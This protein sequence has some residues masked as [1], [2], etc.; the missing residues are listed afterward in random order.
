VID[1]LP[2]RHYPGRYRHPLLVGLRLVVLL[3]LPVVLLLIPLL[4]IKL[5]TEVAL[6]PDIQFWPAPIRDPNVLVSFDVSPGV[7]GAGMSQVVTAAGRCRPG[8]RVLLLAAGAFM[9]GY[10]LLVVGLGM[11][12][13]VLTPLRTVQK[14]GQGATVRL[15]QERIAFGAESTKG[16]EGSLALTRPSRWTGKRPLVCPGRYLPVA[17]APGRCLGAGCGRAGC[18]HGCPGQHRVVHLTARAVRR[19]LPATARTT[20]LSYNILRS[21]LG[22]L[23]LLNIVSLGVL[24]LL[25]A[26]PSDRPALLSPAWQSLQPGGSLSLLLL[27]PGHGAAVV[28]HSAASAP[29]PGSPTAQPAASRRAG[30]RA[31]PGAGRGA[32]PVPAPAHGAGSVRP[33]AAF[34]LLVS[35][36]AAVWRARQA[37]RPV[38]PIV[39]RLATA[40][41]AARLPAD[42]QP[43]CGGTCGPTT[44]W[45]R[46]TGCVTRR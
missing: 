30:R 8:S 44:I 29:G 13:I 12:A 6:V 32:S 18:A 31:G 35:G 37:G 28:V 10:L 41:V 20:D 15:D 40:A 1:G 36:E 27:L 14:H 43:C 45:S 11:A 19:L 21:P 33:L 39:V 25:A 26:T 5:G 22:V 4:T 24:G 16:G 34:V 42:G 7:K 3:A 38:Y 17:C 23:Y 9:L 46:A 2:L